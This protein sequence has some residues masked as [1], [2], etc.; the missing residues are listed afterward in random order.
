MTPVQIQS[1]GRAVRVTDR[2]TGDVVVDVACAKFAMQVDPEGGFS[3]QV[4]H[5]SPD[6]LD[7]APAPSVST[8]SRECLD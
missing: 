5:W 6:E 1:D 7:I 2:K 3:I 8:R 4:E